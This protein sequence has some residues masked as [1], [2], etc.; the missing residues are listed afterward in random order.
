[1]SSLY[2]QNRLTQK[3]LQSRQRE[4]VEDLRG[5]YFRDTTAILHSY[6]FRRLKHKTQ[7]FFAPKND[8]I[9]TRIEHVMH[10]ASISAAICRALDLDSDLAWAIGFGHDLGHAPFGHVGEEILS[11][12]MKKKG[13]G[14]KKF[15]HEIYS[16]RVVDSLARYGAGLNLTYAVRDGIINHCGE[17][18]EQFLEPDF[19]F[20]DLSLLVARDQ[21]PATWE[22]CVV[23]MSDKIAYMGR[24]MEDAKQLGII[25]SDQIPSSVV[26][27]LGD[28]NGRI[29]DTLVNDLITT[30]LVCGKIGFSD[31]IYEAFLALKDFNVKNIY[32]SSM[33]VSYHTNL[34]RILV[35]LY[36]YLEGLFQAFGLD[37][38]KYQSEK[39]F[40]SVRFAEY[41]AKMKNF[42]DQ[43]SSLYEWTILDYIAGMSDDFAIDAVKEIMIPLSFQNQFSVTSFD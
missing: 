33:L 7:V 16:L 3:Q 14:T 23:R 25:T 4:R 8:H 17:K 34:E 24:D 10:V 15:C 2:F 37:F 42:Y 5:A 11:K 27:R 38:Q 20:R 13:I 22:G 12:I 29:I 19:C 28:S 1:M 6:P 18:H 35:T 40:I 21:N 41:L 43:S 36:D 32:R 9:C 39:N 30:S 31:A 26:N